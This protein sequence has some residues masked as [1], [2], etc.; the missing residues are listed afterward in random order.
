MCGPRDSSCIFLSVNNATNKQAN[1][2][3]N[4]LKGAS[5]NKTSLLP[6]ESS[7]SKHVELCA[8]VFYGLIL[9]PEIYKQV[10]VPNID[11]FYNHK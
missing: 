2:V 5:V 1:K 6:A 3:T 9:F 10:A 7:N 4:K 8:N 11:M